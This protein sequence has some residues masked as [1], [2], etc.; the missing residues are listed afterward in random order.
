MLDFSLDRHHTD[1]T[2]GFEIAFDPMPFRLADQAPG[3][4]ADR[5]THDQK[6]ARDDVSSPLGPDLPIFADTVNRRPRH[7][8]FVPGMCL[9]ICHWSVLRKSRPAL[10]PNA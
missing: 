7:L 8:L 6:N 1:P 3:G 10:A 4:D 2:A 5:N 9:L